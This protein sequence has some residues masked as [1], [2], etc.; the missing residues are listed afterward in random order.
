MSIAAIFQLTTPYS[1]TQLSELGY[2]QSLD[3]FVLTHM[4]YAPRRL[5]R[6]DHNDWRIDS[7]PIGVAGAQP[8]T[9]IVSRTRNY[10]DNVNGGYTEQNYQYGVTAVDLTTGR[11]SPPTDTLSVLN[12]LGTR[13]GSPLGNF[14]TI[15]WDAVANAEVY[16]IYSKKNGSYGY[17]GTTDASAPQSFIDDNILPDYSDSPPVLSNPFPVGNYPAVVTFHDRRAFYGR[18]LKK[19]S[20]AYGSQTDDVFNH[21]KS[22]PLR[23]TDSIATSLISRRLNTIRHL[24]SLGNLL[25][26]TSDG[27]FS[28]R[29]TDGGGLTPMGIETKTEGFQGVGSARPEAIDTVG[30]YTTARGNR[31][32]TIG[33]TFERDGFKGNDITV[34]APHLFQGFDIVA[35]AWCEEPSRIMWCLRS[36]GKL[37]ALTWQA[38]QDVW[39]W[40]LCE[41]DGV[42]ESICSVSE[43]G[44][45]VLYMAVRRTINAAQVRY[46]ERLTDPVWMD[47]NWASLPDAVVMD[48]SYTY[49]GTAA[50]ALTGLHWLEGRSV[51]VLA[52]GY[53]VTG[54]T[55]VAGRLTPDLPNAATVIS[56]GLPYESYI[57]TLPVVAQT[58]SGSTVGR[59]QSVSNVIIKVMNTLGIRVGTGD[60]PVLASMF[61]A[62]L[63]DDVTGDTPR[64]PYTGDLDTMGM[65]PGDW[66]TAKVTIAQ[67]QPLPMVVLGVFP[68]INMGR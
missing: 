55:V 50:V 63:P 64:P 28:L 44:R 24:L 65:D 9:A 2:E 61:D 30:F 10:T 62:P 68:D 60:N 5:R 39:G 21:D 66:K 40:T 43:E 7:A 41:T 38:E 58:G 53:V 57:R 17:I 15:V 59:R 14:N 26:L 31:V 34:F 25:A 12:D 13:P 67:L 27:I 3:G 32:R 29:P 42:I 54:R 37:V 49:R 36:D 23:A 11:E 8:A 19:P 52:D 33:Y 56:V 20:A 4:S 47:E 45:D 6:F 1:D 35:M 18:T 22:R 46:I 16:R 51:A 48:S